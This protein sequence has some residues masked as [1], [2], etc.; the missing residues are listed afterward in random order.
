M[1]LFNV[2]SAAATLT[3]RFADRPQAERDLVHHVRDTLDAI[4]NAFLGKRM[5]QPY[6]DALAVDDAVLRRAMGEDFGPA[7]ADV[8]IVSRDLDAKLDALRGGLAFLDGNWD[9]LLDV[10][11][12]T[13]RGGQIVG[14]YLL[15][16]N[17]EG[18]RDAAV[19]FAIF[20][21]P[22]SPATGRVPPG[23]YYVLV[24]KIDGQPLQKT[25]VHVSGD[26]HSVQAVVVELYQ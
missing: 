2:E 15:R 7:L 22:T 23:V 21:N 26:R 13:L 11:V 17:M 6:V 5:A 14:G 18:M 25:L 16:M 1:V 10:S 4:D 12:K 9:G 3:D 8:A 24:E 19:P 20:N